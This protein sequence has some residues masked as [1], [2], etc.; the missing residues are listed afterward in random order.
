MTETA[1]QPVVS[2]RARVTEEVRVGTRFG[3]AI[4]YAWKRGRR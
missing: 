2:K 1:E 3:N 4:Q